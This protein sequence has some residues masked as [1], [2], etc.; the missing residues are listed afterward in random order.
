ME[1]GVLCGKKS[2]YNSGLFNTEVNYSILMRSK[3]SVTR[4]LSLQFA[5]SLSLVVPAH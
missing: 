5:I 4:Y 3:S 1:A 2:L